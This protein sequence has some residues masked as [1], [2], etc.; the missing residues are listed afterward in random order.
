MSVVGFNRNTR[1]IWT[2]IAGRFESEPVVDFAG[3]RTKNQNW[4]FIFDE[5]YQ[6]KPA[7]PG[8]PTGCAVDKGRQRLLAPLFIV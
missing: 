6:P 5:H 7:V 4:P 3:M 2:G 1:S 8:A